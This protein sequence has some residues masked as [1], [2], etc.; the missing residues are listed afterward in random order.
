M[1]ALFILL[2]VV[3][4]S[5]SLAG[6]AWAAPGGDE[7]DAPPAEEQKSEGE[8]D[9]VPVV[10]QLCEGN[11]AISGAIGDAVGG[12]AGA[13]AEAAGDAV[14]SGVLDQATEWMAGGAMWV[15]EQI[16]R[17]VEATTTPELT[18]GWYRDQLGVMIALGLGL[19][20][21]V[22]M[23]GLASAALRRDPEAL[24]AVFIGMFRAGILTG[25][26]LPLTVLA[27]GVAD[28]FSNAVSGAATGGAADGWWEQVGKAWEGEKPGGFPS[29]IAFAFALVQVLAG[30]A[31]WLELL[32]RQAV[33]YVAVLFM[34]LALA[35]S[36]WPALRGWQS[37][38]GSILLVFILLKPIIITILA[39]AGSA[40]AAGLGGGADDEVGTVLAAIVILA[41]AAFS[42]W[43]VMALVSMDSESTWKAGMASGATRS[44]AQ[45]GQSRVGGGLGAA[46]SGAGAAAG[47]TRK[48]GSRGGSSGGSSGGGKGGGSKAGGGKS[49]AQGGGQNAQEGS[50]SATAT[51]PNATMSMAGG[52]AGGAVA[53]AS[54]QKAAGKPGESVAAGTQSASEGATG[55]PAGGS[56]PGGQ[57]QPP[58]GQQRQD[59]QGGGGQ[60]AGGQGGGQGAGAGGGQGSPGGRS[61]VPSSQPRGGRPGGSSKTRGS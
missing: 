40:A 45:Q 11:R 13:G 3:V 26:V 15:S 14:S 22:A 41:L 19:A 20:S 56:P 6:T 2:V 31:V 44:S 52:G 55:S 43:A 8:C 30:I 37:K 23:M 7:G 49:G 5:L 58:A 18:S 39:L 42:P 25:L 50:G 51:Q 1:R 59:S 9:A 53:A 21:L 61:V 34:P 29:V 10:D 47:A 32:I 33:I 12:V 24:G 60:R 38:L 27:L 17:G 54:G 28:E 16:Q 35:A 46:A 48:L 57:S 36:I 4:G